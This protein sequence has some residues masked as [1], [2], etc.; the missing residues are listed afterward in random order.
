M[1]WWRII[2]FSTSLKTYGAL[3]WMF[4]CETGH[5]K[6]KVLVTFLKAFKRQVTFFVL[7]SFI[8]SCTFREG[9]SSSFL[10]FIWPDL[11][12]EVILVSVSFYGMNCTSSKNKTFPYEALRPKVTET[13]QPVTILSSISEINSAQGE[14]NNVA[15]YWTAQANIMM[16][17]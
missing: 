12:T 9:K 2:Q 7:C 4:Y 6:L 17:S 13:C 14:D 3:F 11:R 15:F 8:H 1:V 10:I 5:T 16:V